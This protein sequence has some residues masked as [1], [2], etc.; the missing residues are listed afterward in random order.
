[1]GNSYRT[2]EDKKTP[3][4]PGALFLPT[5]TA[6]EAT[7]ANSDVRRLAV[8]LATNRGEHAREAVAE[9]ANRGDNRNGDAGGDQAILDGGCAIFV[10]GEIAKILDHR[11][12]P[13]VFFGFAACQNTM[14]R[15]I[16][17][18]V[19]GPNV[20]HSPNAARDQGFTT[21]GPADDTYST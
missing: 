9:Q 21:D 11:E 14:R 3:L 5:G 19:T 10:L 17:I 7:L 16:D 13:C 20:I 4:K 15:D 6:I 2:L 1:M 12:T 8:D 18:A